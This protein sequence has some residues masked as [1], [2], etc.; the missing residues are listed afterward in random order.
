MTN[1]MFSILNDTFNRLLQDG[2][3]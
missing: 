3:S 2:V 1:F